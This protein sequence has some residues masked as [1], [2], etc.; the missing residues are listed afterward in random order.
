MA[1][2]GLVFQTT[3]LIHYELYEYNFTHYQNI[4]QVIIWNNSVGDFQKKCF[5]MIV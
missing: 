4:F 3:I 2:N 5:K 1:L